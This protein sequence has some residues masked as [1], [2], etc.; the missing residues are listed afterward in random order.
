MWLL[1]FLP[2]SPAPSQSSLA[3]E[4]APCPGILAGGHLSGTDRPESPG[5]VFG[6][7]TWDCDDGHLVGKKRA[8]SWKER[9]PVVQVP[10]KKHP[11]GGEEQI[12]AVEPGLSPPRGYNPNPRPSCGST[13]FVRSGMGCCAVCQRGAAVGWGGSSQHSFVGLLEVSAPFLCLPSWSSVAPVASG[14]CPV[15]HQGSQCSPPSPPP[16]LLTIVQV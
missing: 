1:L 12:L 5:L 4:G 7:R 10:L 13:G 6:A 3:V 15:W 2:P 14:T 8:P 9:S 16:A 11:S